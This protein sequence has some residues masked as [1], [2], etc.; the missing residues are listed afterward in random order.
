LVKELREFPGQ[1]E[2]RY[3]VRRQVASAPLGYPEK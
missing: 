1:V 3:P 2:I